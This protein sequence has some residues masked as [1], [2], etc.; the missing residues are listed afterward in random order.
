MRIRSISPSA[1]CSGNGTRRIDG[2]SRT[3][4]PAPGHADAKVGSK[5]HPD[6]GPRR[7]AE[8]QHHPLG[9]AQEGFP[10]RDRGLAGTL[11][12]D[13]QGI[14]VDGIWTT[15]RRGVKDAPGFEV[16]EDVVLGH[17]SFA[18]Y[19]MWK[20]LVDRHRCAAIES[21]C[22]ASHRLP[23]RPVP[24]RDRLRRWRRHR[25]VLQPIRPPRPP[26]CGLVPDGRDRDG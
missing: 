13:K 18:K 7:R 19:L 15:V 24:K 3:A 22:P 4:D 21:R 5:R 11:P 17:F 1:F 10:D 2:D 12:T 23:P 8:I 9:N 6:A 25:P 16:T 26:A 14:D 20:D